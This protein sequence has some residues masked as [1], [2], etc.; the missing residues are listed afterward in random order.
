MFRMNVMSRM[1]G[2]EG[3]TRLINIDR[4]TGITLPHID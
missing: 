3:V 2:Y 4:I 1:H